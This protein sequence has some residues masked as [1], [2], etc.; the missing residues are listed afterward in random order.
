MSVSSLIDL[1]VVA[2][3]A[4]G[5]R[6]VH[7]IAERGADGRI[8]GCEPA[9]GVHRG[10]RTVREWAAVG[11]FVRDSSGAVAEREWTVGVAFDLPPA[12][13]DRAV[14]VVAQRHEIREMVPA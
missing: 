11:A 4:D 14:V 5:P 3:D 1:V 8:V 9:L 2:D 7:P 13:V 12:M 6:S 10:E